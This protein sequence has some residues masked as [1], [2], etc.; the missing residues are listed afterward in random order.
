MTRKPRA[1]MA[2]LPLSALPELREFLAP[3]MGHGA[4][5]GHVVM[6]RLG[7]EALTQLDTL[8]EAGLFGSRSEAA[9]F[10]VGAGVEAQRGLF[11]RITRQTAAIQRLRRS[12]RKAALEAL[13]HG[14]VAAAAPGTQRTGAP[15]PPA[16]PGRSPRASRST[17]PGR[18]TTRR[19]AT[20]GEAP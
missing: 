12:M 9:A 16:K 7:D 5:R 17:T 19:R 11:A 2:A 6:V 10:L 15:R 3:L 20:T 14:R 13:K 4:R 1:Y 8:V 18:R